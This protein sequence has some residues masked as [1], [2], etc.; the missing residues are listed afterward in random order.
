MPVRRPE[1]DVFPRLTWSLLLDMKTSRRIAHS[2]LRARA[3]ARARRL[4]RRRRRG[5]ARGRRRGRRRRARSRKSDYDALISQAKKSYKTRSASS[6]RPGT[7]EYQTLK[8]QAVQFLVQ[9]EQFEQEAAELDVEV[10]DKQVDDA[11]RADQEAVLRRR[12]EE[13]REAA[14]GAGAHRRAGAQRHPRASSSPRR[15]SRRSPTR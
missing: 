9:R 4:R 14:E 2:S 15:S 1:P 8:N 5:R 11:A 3:R 13:V 6:R 12:P 7:Q 10:T